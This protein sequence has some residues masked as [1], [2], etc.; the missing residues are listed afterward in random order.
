VTVG[1]GTLASFWFSNWI[2][3]TATR[4]IAP[5][6]FIKAKR[7]NIKVQK[8]LL[9]NTWISLISSVSGETEIIEFVRL[10]EAI[11]EVHINIEEVDKIRWRILYQE[12]LPGSVPREFC[13]T[14][15]FSSL[16]GEDGA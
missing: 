14:Q 10:W 2:N 3:G 16:E 11:H 4:L 9:D 13:Q 15:T 8:A 6:L 1:N 12:C 7:K 5:N